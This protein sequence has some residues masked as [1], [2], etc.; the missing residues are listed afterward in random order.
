MPTYTYRCDSCGTFAVIRPMRESTSS[1][2]CTGC[3]SAA[4]RVFEAPAL[5]SVAPGMHR[6]MDAAAASAE[7][8]RVVRNIPDA[9][10]V[11]RQR[12]PRR[13]SPKHPPLPRM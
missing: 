13:M 6:A 7:Q 2:T 5:A 10:G 3:D 11:P 8:P 1:A 12:Q 4:R 9:A